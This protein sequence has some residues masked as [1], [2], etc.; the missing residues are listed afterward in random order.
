MPSPW[1]KGTDLFD[2]RLLITFM[3]DMDDTTI[4]EA[5]GTTRGR[6]V[7]WKRG[8]ANMTPWWKAD[9]LAIRIGTH[10]SAIWPDWWEKALQAA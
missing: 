1:P 8:K 2:L 9:A 4:A 7:D 5:L 3:G 6:V 10:P